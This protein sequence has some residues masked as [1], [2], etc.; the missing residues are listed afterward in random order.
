MAIP[1]AP[2]FIA[3]STSKA[4]SSISMTTSAGVSSRSTI[5][6]A[7]GLNSTYAGFT[8]KKI[9][10]VLYDNLGNQTSET[11]AIF[12]ESTLHNTTD[13]AA[14]KYFVNG[15]AG[16]LRVKV[17]ACNLEQSINSSST[18]T[19]VHNGTA[20][21]TPF[22]GAIVWAV[23]NQE[24]RNYVDF[25]LATGS[26]TTP[27]VTFTPGTS[28]PNYLAFGALLTQGPSGDTFTQASTWSTATSSRVGTTGGSA[29]SNA[30]I[31]TGYKQS[32]GS[33]GAAITWAPTIG[34]SRAWVAIL[35]VVKDPSPTDM[36]WI[37][38][39]TGSW[40]NANTGN[41]AT[42]SGGTAVNDFPDGYTN[43]HI[44]DHGYATNLSMQ[45][46]INSN[47][48][49]PVKC[50]S[51]IITREKLDL[52]SDYDGIMIY[53]E[54]LQTTLATPTNRTI[55]LGIIFCASQFDIQSTDTGWVSSQSD[56][57]WV[58][59]GKSATTSGLGIYPIR[60]DGGSSSAAQ[61]ITRWKIVDNILQ[62]NTLISEAATSIGIFR[63]I[64][65]INN[66]PANPRKLQTYGVV[67]MRGKLFY[68]G[69]VPVKMLADYI[70]T[71]STDWAA[72]YVGID[73]GTYGYASV[74]LSG[75]SSQLYT[76]Y[77]HRFLNPISGAFVFDGAST[78]QTRTVTSSQI[79]TWTWFPSFKVTSGG[80]TFVIAG[81]DGGFAGVREVDF[82]GCTATLT[83]SSSQTYFGGSTTFATNMTVT[84][85]ATNQA[86]F[87][88]ELGVPATVRC[89]GT[90]IPLPV[91]FAQSGASTSITLYDAFTTTVNASIS[92]TLTLFLNG[93]T[94]T[95]PIMTFSDGRV[96]GRNNSAS[97]SYGK[98]TVNGTAA[99]VIIDNSTNVTYFYDGATVETTGGG[100]TT[101]LIYTG[102]ATLGGL[103]EF[104]KSI[105]LS[106]KNTAGSVTVSS[107]AT[108]GSQG[109]IRNLTLNGT[110]TLTANSMSVWGNYT[111]VAGT[112]TAGTQFWYLGG[113]AGTTSTLNFGGVTHDLNL[114]VGGSIGAVWNNNEVI[115]LGS[116]LTLGAT[117]SFNVLL[118]TTT[119]GA[120]FKTNNYN[121]T[122]NAM[123]SGFSGKFTAGTS[124][125]TLTGVNGQISA[126]NVVFQDFNSGPNAAKFD[127]ASSTILLSNTTTSARTL[128]FTNLDSRY[129]K[130][131]IGGTTGISTTT[132]NL[133]YPVYITELASTKTVAHTIL[134]TDTTNVN[135]GTWSV[136]GT[137]GN[138]VTIGR[139]TAGGQVSLVSTGGIQYGPINYLSFSNVAGS[140]SNTWYVGANSTNGANNTGLIFTAAPPK[141]KAQMLM[142]FF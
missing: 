70:Q 124:T 107:T 27:S 99:G 79:P 34:T 105:P 65:L 17:F 29:T 62:T 138:V 131:T 130:I 63:G 5:Y 53:G 102:L 122:A 118:S 30:T 59:Q 46:A 12:R 22:I 64:V 71:G 93:N 98:I 32:V 21:A 35:I 69:T 4:V 72:N 26:S 104:E 97:G 75:L 90:T 134:F 18:I 106:I 49:R 142:M 91:V 33:T 44:D 45:V 24:Y 73:F 40:D 123:N 85:S 43:V 116:A 103:P 10:V 39:N 126:G 58:I 6:V 23:A 2:V 51:L 57:Y 141:P 95:T 77:S 16:G 129:G 13:D 80:G 119:N 47:A 125:I 114:V 133:G 111:Y 117:K 127:G 42:S 11:S 68:N 36:Y 20:G 108:V 100:A 66:D 7:V 31:A 74:Q 136:T 128:S 135:I 132:F 137:A 92:N 41:F 112:I 38:T 67:D 25:A 94:L 50:R 61:Y 54:L 14:N 87:A 78:T 19:I 96:W 48:H 115:Q 3:S 60:F 1:Q 110:F 37:A 89:N 121:I 113:A 86:N 56:S 140:P 84:S 101:K 15:T 76:A 28:S 120:E 88:A 82:T 83:C 9:D 52:S 55:N 139:S 8:D 109:V 81:T